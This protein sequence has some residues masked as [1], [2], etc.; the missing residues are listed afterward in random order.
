MN[1]F[2]EKKNGS[3]V[4]MKVYESIYKTFKKINNF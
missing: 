1:L 2:T 4:L 3:D